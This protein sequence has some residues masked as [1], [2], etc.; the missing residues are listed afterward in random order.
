MVSAGTRVRARLL[1]S[2]SVES[3]QA[4][5]STVSPVVGSIRQQCTGAV[6]LS[7]ERKKAPWP[8][9]QGAE[10]QG[11]A[12]REGLGL[13]QGAPQVVVG[14]EPRGQTENRVAVAAGQGG[15]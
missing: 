8:A 12:C 6:P 15:V 1:R 9:G 13:V 4:G 7:Q 5:N 14:V 3:C 11:H 10:R 2:P